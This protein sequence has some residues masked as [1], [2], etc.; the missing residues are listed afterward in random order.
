MSS[1]VLSRKSTFE[2]EQNISSDKVCTK[3]EMQAPKTQSDKTKC[4]PEGIRKK[5]IS[6][7]CLQKVL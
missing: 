2:G 5:V 1:I 7:I 6:E 3:P 4:I